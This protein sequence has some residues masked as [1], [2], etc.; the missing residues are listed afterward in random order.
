MPMYLG[1]AV[2]DEYLQG[3]IAAYRDGQKEAGGETAV[4]DSDQVVINR[5]TEKQVTQATGATAEQLGFSDAGG[6]RGDL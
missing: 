5:L 6:E 3:L 4:E 1:Q 2:T